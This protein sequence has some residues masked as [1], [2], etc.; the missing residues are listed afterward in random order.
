MKDIRNT[1]RKAG[2]DWRL[3]GWKRKLLRDLR[4]LLAA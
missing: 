1:Y 2:F 3:R 4:K